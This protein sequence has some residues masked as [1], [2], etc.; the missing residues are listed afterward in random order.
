MEF[1]AGQ[2]P[3]VAAVCLGPLL[4][5]VI[6]SLSGLSLL[7]EKDVGIWQFVQQAVLT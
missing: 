7:A 4:A 5:A 1:R 2:R 3:L 6:H